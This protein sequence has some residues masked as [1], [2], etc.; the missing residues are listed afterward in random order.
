MGR[1]TV[2]HVRHV[3]RRSAYRSL[4]PVWTLVVGVVYVCVAL[5][6]VRRNF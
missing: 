6:R 4:E 5:G 2:G 3:L 1:N